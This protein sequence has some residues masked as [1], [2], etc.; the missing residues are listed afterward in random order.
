MSDSGTSRAVAEL[1]ADLMER[2]DEIPGV[3]VVAPECDMWLH[4]QR[5]VKDWLMGYFVA[6]AN[7]ACPHPNHEYVEGAS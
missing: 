2:V 6:A 1:L 7:G 3:H 5:Q 4:T